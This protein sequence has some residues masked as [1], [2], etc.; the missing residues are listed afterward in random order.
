MAPLSSPLIVAVDVGGTWVR[1]AIAEADGSLGRRHRV[2]TDAASGPAAVVAQIAA[3]VR[4]VA[5]EGDGS[6]PVSLVA[7]AVPGPVDPYA[8][9]VEGTPNL[10]GWAKVPLRRLLEVE[11][12]C[13]C[14][15]DHDATVAALAEQRRGAG[16]GFANF[17]YIT[18]STGIGAGLI[19]NNQLYRGGSGRAGEFGHMVVRPDGPLCGCG[20][21]G[22][23]EAVASG[24]AIARDSGR[25]T[26]EE[27]ARAAE[28]GDPRA[29]SVMA[30]AARALGLGV[31]ALINLLD[32][33]CIALGGGVLRSG[34]SFW[35]QMVAA[36]AEGSFASIRADCRIL[37][38][39][40]GE[41]QGLLGA[42]EFALDELRGNGL[43][44]RALE[45]GGELPGLGGHETA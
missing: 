5:P 34:N 9:V 23:L 36:V 2:A 45:R 19:L 41:E 16:R 12:R 31:G 8:G 4:A 33:D 26:A 1:A 27:V 24:T 42:V 43:G 25:G 22:C 7:V 10:T 40:L 17:A 15:I 3:A 21:R 29:M 13:R 39:E 20:N 44:V 28:D 37:R 38:A 6:A 11:L 32:L 30:G 14:V 35:E 18:V